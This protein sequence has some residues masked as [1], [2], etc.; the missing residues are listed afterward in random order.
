M[1]FIKFLGQKFV[2]KS[3][4][5]KA[6][7]ELNLLLKRAMSER[8]EY[9][10]KFEV[11]FSYLTEYQRNDFGKKVGCQIICEKDIRDHMKENGIKWR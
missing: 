4:V 3:F 5:I 7:A 6:Y 1:N 9:E 8:N 11:A 2:P 10:K